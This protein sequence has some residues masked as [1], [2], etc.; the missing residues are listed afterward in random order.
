MEFVSVELCG[1]LRRT[2]VDRYGRGAPEEL[3]A[4]TTL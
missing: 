2:G 3:D 4:P 1:E